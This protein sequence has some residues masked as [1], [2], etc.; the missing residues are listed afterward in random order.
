MSRGRVQRLTPD[1]KA[2]VAIGAGVREW[3]DILLVRHVKRTADGSA[4]G[5]MTPAGTDH[6]AA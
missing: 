2:R 5:S 1:F 6:T 3:A 4:D